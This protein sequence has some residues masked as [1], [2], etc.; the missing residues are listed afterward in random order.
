[1]ARPPLAALRVLDD[2]VVDCY[3]PALALTLPEQIAWAV[4]VVRRPDDGGDDDEDAGAAWLR[5][6]TALLR[7]PGAAR[8]RTLILDD[9][10]EHALDP[11]DV[12][13]EDGDP[14]PLMKRHAHRLARL[15]RL[16]IGPCPAE[17]PPARGV[18]QGI[19]PALAKLPALQRLDLHGAQG[20]ELVPTAGHPRLRTLV[21]HVA[22]AADDPL[23]A[24]VAAPFPALARLDV[25]LGPE[26]A[27]E[28]EE[29]A[30][31][32]ALASGR[33]PGLRE[34]GLRGLESPTLLDGLVAHELGLESLTITH[35]PGLEDD[36]V[37][38][39][40]SA[41]W[42]R[43]LRRLELRGTGVSAALRAELAAQGPELVGGD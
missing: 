25:W 38:R 1:M 42:L 22:E 17:L 36:G 29:E 18:C 34:L 32:A 27:E 20:W 12:A 8:L 16:H 6:L 4:S 40:L 43:R 39:L 3:D 28:H 30:F 35:S 33:F 14:L 21:M 26:V 31:G 9:W 5:L 15:E 7:D 23:A 19:G 10:T 41:S 2:Q 24:L 37:A 13:Y 11:C